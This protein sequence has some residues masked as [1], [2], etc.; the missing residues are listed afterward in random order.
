V[1]LTV[2]GAMGG[3]EAVERLLQIA[4]KAKV[5]ASSGYSTDPVMADYEQYGFVAVVPKP[6]E[7]AEL[8]EVVHRAIAG[9]QE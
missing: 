1:D 2:P 7:T 3:E 5:I 8:A 4:P 9:P 6:Y